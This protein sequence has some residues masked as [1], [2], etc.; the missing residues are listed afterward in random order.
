MNTLP[1]IFRCSGKISIMFSHDNCG[2]IT[3]VILLELWSF[4]QVI[5]EICSALLLLLLLFCNTHQMIYFL[6]LNS[7]NNCKKK[8][9]VENLLHCSN[10][11]I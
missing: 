8:K 3:S 10:M 2:E 4:V 9:L 1:V 11:I 7:V 5:F 6:V